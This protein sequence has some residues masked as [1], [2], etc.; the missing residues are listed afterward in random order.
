MPLDRSFLRDTLLPE[1]ELLVRWITGLDPDRRED[2]L[3][4]ERFFDYLKIKNAFHRV[5]LHHEGPRGFE[6][7]QETFDLRK[8]YFRTS[9]LGNF[10]SREGERVRRVAS[11]LEGR[12]LA[13]SAECAV[14]DALGSLP[15]AGRHMAPLDLEVRVSFATGREFRDSLRGWCRG[16]EGVLER[17]PGLPLRVGFV[18]HAI[19]IDPEKDRFR[20]L[21]LFDGLLDILEE[22]PLLRPMIVGIDAASRELRSP[23]R[24]FS[25]AYLGVRERLNQQPPLPGAWPIRLGFTF[26]A[27][28]D[29]PDLLTGIRHVDEAAHLLGMRPGDR[30]GHALALAWDPGEYYAKARVSLPSRL[31]QVLDLLWMGTLFST[32]SSDEK[33]PRAP[34][35]L[36]KRTLEILKRITAPLPP[37]RIELAQNLLGPSGPHAVASLRELV[38]HL[39]HV[40]PDL[41]ADIED[42]IRY[43]DPYL[44]RRVHPLRIVLNESLLARV[45]GLGPCAREE[46]CEIPARIDAWIELVNMAQRITRH[47][48]RR[49][50]LVI[51]LNPSS[52]RIIGELGSTRELPYLRLNRYGLDGHSRDEQLPISINTDNPGIFHTSLRNEYDLVGRSLLEDHDVRSVSD[53]LDEA[54]RVSLDSSF[55]PAW[56]PKGAELLRH[57]RAILI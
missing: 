12:R 46:M 48:V 38:R 42:Y 30:I 17:W 14:L 33:E 24:T 52:N 20:A 21:H 36:V 9:T 19:K 2:I 40:D 18:V 8:F 13:Q 47:R 44:P 31:D 6:R 22:N 4:L 54:R 16:L 49:Q 35:T 39:V 34:E 5:L 56:S 37:G 23:P 29:F 1:R 32:P 3:P 11:T 53:W 41:G 45:L 50:N 28:E 27:G 43:D 55:I 25:D 57:V 26:H 10:P 7:F 51:E 15:E